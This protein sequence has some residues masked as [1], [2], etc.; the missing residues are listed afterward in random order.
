MLGDL[1]ER[2]ARERIADEDLR[3]GPRVVRGQALLDFD[4][5]MNFLP[6]FWSLFLIV[7][8]RD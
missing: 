6:D 5:D 3:Q 8:I 4:D 2:A 1:V 7:K